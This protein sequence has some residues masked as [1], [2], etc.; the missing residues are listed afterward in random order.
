MLANPFEKTPQKILSTQNLK[1]PKKAKKI[2]S[3]KTP[4]LFIKEVE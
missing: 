4:D 2:T 1:I 3:Q